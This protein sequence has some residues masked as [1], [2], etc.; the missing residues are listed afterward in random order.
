VEGDDDAPSDGIQ[1]GENTLDDDV[2][3]QHI[4]PESILDS[5]EESVKLGNH[6]SYYR[7]AQ[8]IPNPLH[9]LHKERVVGLTHNSSLMDQTVMTDLG[10][11]INE[12]IQRDGERVAIFVDQHGGADTG[13]DSFVKAGGPAVAGA[14]DRDNLSNRIGRLISQTATPSMTD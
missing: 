2:T 11:R 5:Q 7:P 13:G 10:V 8:G 9:H 1:D 14:S 4:R 3:R 12:G 6:G